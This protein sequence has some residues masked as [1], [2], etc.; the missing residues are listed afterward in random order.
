M[1]GISSGAAAFASVQIGQR[2]ENEGKLLVCVLPSFG[3]R[4]L[5]TPLFQHIRKANM[6]DDKTFNT[7]CL[8]KTT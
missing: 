1:V 4:Y 5:S 7:A 8:L 6:E 3:E 2:P